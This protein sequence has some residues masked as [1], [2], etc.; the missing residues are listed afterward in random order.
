MIIPVGF[1]F[2]KLSGLSNELKLKLNRTLPRNMAQVNQM[3]GMTP[4]AALLIAAALQRETLRD[5]I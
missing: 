3:E 2:E 1:S 4:A 5:A